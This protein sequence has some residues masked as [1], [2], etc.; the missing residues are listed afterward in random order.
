MDVASGHYL[1]LEKHI[2]PFPYHIA[3]TQNQGQQWAHLDN[4]VK[5][6]TPSPPK[7]IAEQQERKT[8]GRTSFII[9]MKSMY[10]QED[11]KK[12]S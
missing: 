8:C 10:Q 1:K 5:K 12:Q 3:S 9:H 6:M 11:H 7:K 2:H 4:E